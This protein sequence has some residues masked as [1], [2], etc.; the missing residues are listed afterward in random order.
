MASKDAGVKVYLSLGANQ[1][2]PLAQLRAAVKI[3]ARHTRVRLME[4]SSVFKTA[5]IGPEQPDFYNMVIEAE[6]TLSPAE[7]LG[8]A[9]A[10]EALVGREPAAERWGPRM[11]D[12]DILLYGSQVVEEGNLCIP[13]PQMHQRAFVLT[14]LAEIAPRVRFPDGSLVKNCLESTGDQRV[15]P[16]GP[17]FRGPWREEVGCVPTKDR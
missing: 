5:P 9:Q 12:I 8:V 1:G 17:L 6:T 3:L 15:A 2:R 4:I 14:P 16:M 10:V 7:L 11:I 13:H